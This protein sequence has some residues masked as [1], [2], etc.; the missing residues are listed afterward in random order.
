MSKHRT[1]ILLDQVDKEAIARIQSRYGISTDSSAIRLAVRML[2]Q[3]GLDIP[4]GY[5]DGMLA[6]KPKD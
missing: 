2:D 1:T 3:H 4:S 6:P 5:I